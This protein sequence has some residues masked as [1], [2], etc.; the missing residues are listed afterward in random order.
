MASGG[1]A[2]SLE[3]REVLTMAKAMYA[4]SGDPITFGH[5]NIIERAA[6]VFDELVVGIG[7]N[8]SKK[9]MFS[10]EERTEMAERAVAGLPNVSVVSFRGLLV[11]YAYEKGIQVLVK[12]VRDS[13]DFDYEMLLHQAGESQKLGIDTYL[14]PARQD[15]IHV[16]SSVI[17]SILIEQGDVH[18]YVPIH[19]QQALYEKMLDQYLIGVTGEPGV[20]KSH[21]GHLFEQWGRRHGVSVHNIDLDHI[22]NQ[23]LCELSEPAYASVRQQIAREFGQ[24][25]ARADGTIDK[26]VLGE[27]VF[28]DQDSLC[29]LNDLMNLPLTVRLH[30]EMYDKSGI[31]VVNTGLIAE[32]NMTYLCNNN[33]ILV[34]ADHELQRA[35]LREKR[36]TDQQIE[37]RLRSQYTAEQKKE[38]ILQVIDQDNHGKLWKV[39]SSGA[40]PANLFDT[41]AANLSYLGGLNPWHLEKASAG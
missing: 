36:L 15:L 9:Y 1:A 27:L 38:R 13:K 11:N 18:T 2:G 19:V 5:L 26:K 4:F 33:I 41:I 34:T 3:R 25:I 17:K 30:R 16:A 37:R 39:D 35:R 24:E 32:S 14:L 10:L 29:R 7:I 21:I 31:I 23:I 28:H 8:P 20:G 6:R 12:G 22:A 40:V